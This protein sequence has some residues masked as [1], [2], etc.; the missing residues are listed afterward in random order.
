[1]SNSIMTVMR[2]ME[3]G[4][5]TLFHLSSLLPERVQSHTPILCL[6]GQRIGQGPYLTPRDPKNDPNFDPKNVF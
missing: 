1:M 6:E 2:H 5:G 4:P 3:Q